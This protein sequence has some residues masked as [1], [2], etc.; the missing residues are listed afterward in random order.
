MAYSP[1]HYSASR[2]QTLRRLGVE[3]LPSLCAERDYHDTG[4][5][6]KMKRVEYDDVSPLAGDLPLRSVPVS[7]FICWIHIHRSSN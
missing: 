1:D 4:S 6:S 5:S 3:Q 2:C 7:H